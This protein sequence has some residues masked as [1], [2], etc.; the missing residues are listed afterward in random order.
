MTPSS[1]DALSAFVFD[2]QKHLKFKSSLSSRPLSE[3]HFAYTRTYLLELSI[4]PPQDISLKH[5]NQYQQSF[6][7]PSSFVLR[8]IL[9]LA[10]RSI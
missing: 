6:K 4:L 1:L 5:G 9:F 8:Q 2:P 3:M 7:P 10:F